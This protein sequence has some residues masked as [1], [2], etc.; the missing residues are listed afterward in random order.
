LYDVNLEYSLNGEPN[1]RFVFNQFYNPNIQSRPPNYFDLFNATDIAVTGSFGWERFLTQHFVF[2]A[3][4][5]STFSLLDVNH[6]RWRIENE[7]GKYTS[8]HHKMLHLKCSIVYY[9]N[10]VKRLD[11]Y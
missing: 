9:V 2:Q 6:S 3:E 10:R 1:D 4:L 11:V 8:S 5:K 7:A